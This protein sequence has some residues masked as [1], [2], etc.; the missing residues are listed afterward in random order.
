MG[1]EHPAASSSHA[2]HGALTG[3][4]RRRR[5]HSLRAMVAIMATIVLA[6]VIFVAPAAA[7]P[8]PQAPSAPAPAADPKAT[9]EPVVLDPA[10]EVPELRTATSRTYALADGRFAV[11]AFADPVFYRPEGSDTFEPI[12][13]DFASSGDR[14]TQA[15]TASRVQ[16]EVGAQADGLVSLTFDGH[17]IT[18]RPLPVAP[19]TDTTAADTL[20][21]EAP[22]LEAA[23]AGLPA[24]AAP[25]ALDAASVE[26]ALAEPVTAADP[27][28]ERQRVDIANV[29]PGV[30]LRVFAHADGTTNF[31]VLHAR[32]A[33]A[34]WTFAVT[35]PGLTIVPGAD[36]GL[37]F[38]DAEGTAVARMPAPYAVD[39]TP[40]EHTGSGRTTTAAW[41]TL[42]E[43]DDQPLVTV[44]V[45]PAWLADAVY[46]VY[47]DPSVTVYNEGTSANG[48][49]HVNQGNPDFHYANYQRPDSPYYA[50]MWLGESPSNSSYFNM[51]FIQFNIAAYYG[52]VVDTASLEVRP[53]HQY[54]DAPTATRTYLR[55]V[56][57]TWVED[58][59]WDTRPTATSSGM[60]WSD[61]VEGQQCAFDITAMAANWLDGDDA[62]NGIRLDEIDTNGTWKGPTYWKRLI[63][64]EQGTST[65]PRLIL[66]YHNPAVPAYP[67]GGPTAGRT[68]TWTT[69][70]WTT[71]SGY[72]VQVATDTAFT[73]V[74]ASSG[75][76]TGT[77]DTGWAIPAATT[78]APG[79]T[80]YWRVKIARAASDAGTR[81]SPWSAPASFTYDPTLNLGSL[82]HNTFESF[83]LGSGDSLA[84]NVST[85]NL[86]LSHP[87]V[88]LP[89]RGGSLPIGL[90]HNSFDVADTGLGA[91]W[92]LSLQRAVAV[93]GT[94]ATFTDADG[95]RHTFI[96]ASTAGS[97]T[98]WT[99][100]ATL[101]ANLR[102]DTAAT[103][104]E[105]TLTY[106]DQSKD[107]FR[108]SD[109][110]LV[111]TEDRFGNAV[112]IGYAGTHS[113]AP[114]IPRAGRSRSA[115]PRTALTITDWANVA[116][117]IVQASGTPNRTHRVFLASGAVSRVGGRAQHRVDVSIPRDR[118]GAHHRAVSS[119][120]HGSGSLT[121]V[122]KAQTYTTLS[123][124]TLGTGNRT[125]TTTIAYRGT[126]VA[127]VR[128]ATQGS[129]DATTFTRGASRSRSSARA[130]PTPTTTY[131]LQAAT[132]A[133]GRVKDVTRT[134][135]AGGIT[136][137][138]T[139]DT[140]YPTESASVIDNYGASPSR[141]VSY[142][143]HASS[144]ACSRG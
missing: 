93:S 112:T 18:L 75:T 50:E 1:R 23:T 47:V 40:D 131:G 115:G 127:S 46:P 89:I 5:T 53:Y 103:G 111:R 31:L 120:R 7:A 37:D 17:E 73:D 70:T 144:W 105:I 20:E 128:D 106:R 11:E 77:P 124:T 49:V 43:L 6:E 16:V 30:D 121:K 24:D 28:A 27:T 136:Q 95:A 22:A 80:Y 125:A 9:D 65:R 81:W 139:W 91:G 34:A 29:L 87:I 10:D 33:V 54:Y 135:G 13:L 55:R 109:G 126:E 32:P 76:I 4:T 83:D 94:S 84:V 100:P 25:V 8:A 141:T 107:T 78:L 108:A 12:D 14:S 88:T 57:E 58:I 26:A 140:T 51:A 133:Y 117:G 101:Y 2:E 41:Y 69:D 68:L 64:S 98:T 82:G 96:D 45:D 118:P 62:D 99:R 134:L 35:A 3:G 36:G 104:L 110:H 52:N 48:D 129:N 59:T 72:S 142:T 85:G 102:R 92:R 97:V 39:S 21:G 15:V 90:T 67:S 113:R 122:R 63:A 137:R 143:Y 19:S 119:H 61:C 123:G 79:T 38:L 42:S 74:V 138:T 86:V 114:P 132:D 116:G 56:T 66:T 60:T 71:T 130:R 44:S